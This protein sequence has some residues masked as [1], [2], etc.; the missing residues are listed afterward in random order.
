MGAIV[1]GLTLHGLHGF[2][3]GFFVFSDYMKPAIRMAAL[4]KLPSIFIFTHDSVAVGE[5]GPTH[6]PIE[7]LTM[8][9]STP[10]LTVY[11]PADAN[12]TK[13]VYRM[14]LENQEGPSVIVLSRQNL[15]VKVESTWEDVSKGGYVIS[16]IDDFEGILLATGSEVGLAIETQRVLSAKG[17]NV[18]VVSMPSVERFL[19]QSK[20]YQEKV[21][22]TSCTKRL[23]IE[24]GAS[25]GWYRFASHVKGIDTFGVSAPGEQAI[26]NFGFTVKDLVQLYQ[27]I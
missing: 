22:P 15:E 11:R 1:N 24:M 2:G 12:E 21:L 3:G 13:F 14:A 8:F 17:I 18:R 6:E 4:M 27:Q 5:D 7:Q 9:R 10:N 16:D 26:A 25:L 19:K 20:S 23:A